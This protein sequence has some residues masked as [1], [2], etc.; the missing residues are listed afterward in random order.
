MLRLGGTMKLLLILAS[1]A[2]VLVAGQLEE[3]QKP[4]D[5][6]WN[7][8]E[9]RT[10]DCVSSGKKDDCVLLAPN[11]RIPFDITKF[12]CRREPM[13]QTNW[14]TLAVNSTTRLAC[15]LNCPVNFDLSVLQK[16]PYVNKNCQKYYT[17]GKYWDVA[18]NDWYIWQTEPCVAAIST[19]CR[20]N[21][22]PITYN[23]TKATGKNVEEVKLGGEILQTKQSEQRK[24]VV[25]A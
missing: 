9:P 19:H 8:W 21:D 10:I 20:F 15:P 12:K 17:Y 7:R 2:A 24:K 1:S 13:P 16:R 18:A 22:V 6:L 23:P 11:S 3:T 4:D 25:V 5:F 14:N